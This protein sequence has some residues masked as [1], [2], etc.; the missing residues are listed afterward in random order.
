MTR[1]TMRWVQRKEND[2]NEKSRH[3]GG[4]PQTQVKKDKTR[5]KKKHIKFKEPTEQRKKRKMEKMKRK[6]VKQRKKKEKN[7]G[8]QRQV[9]EQRQKKRSGKRKHPS[10]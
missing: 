7:E 6:Q 4:T 2:K 10:K 9:K 3:Y 5:T 1:R 8:E